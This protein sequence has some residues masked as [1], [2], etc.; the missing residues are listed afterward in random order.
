M[1]VHPEDI[2]P[3]FRMVLMRA[4]RTWGHRGTGA[5][6]PTFERHRQCAFYHIAWIPSFVTSHVPLKCNSKLEKI[7][8]PRFQKIQVSIF[9]GGVY[10]QTP[11][12]DL[13]LGTATICKM[14]LV[15]LSVSFPRQG[16]QS[17]CQKPCQGAPQSMCPHFYIA[18]YVPA[19]TYRIVLPFTDISCNMLKA[20]KF[21]MNGLL[22]VIK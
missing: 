12:A 11:L 14:F 9:P 20:K 21:S 16:V 10:P 22:P 19:P 8:L 4:H 18:S 5:R 2:P 3:T 7:R 15:S 1:T 17:H 6:A 13:R